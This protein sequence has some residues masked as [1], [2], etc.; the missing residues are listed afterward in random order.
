VPGVRT[1]TL[2]IAY[3]DAGPADGV[4]PPSVEDRHAAMFSGPYR[5]VLVPRAGHF[6]PREAPG[7]VAEAVRSLSGG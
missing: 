3:L 6:L 4:G 5:R 1:A 2:E 7:V